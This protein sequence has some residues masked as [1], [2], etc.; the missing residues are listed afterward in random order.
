[1]FA[2]VDLFPGLGLIAETYEMESLLMQGGSGSENNHLPCT[3]A[4]DDCLSRVLGQAW[5]LVCSDH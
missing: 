3:P 1:M 4:I 5:W 2:H